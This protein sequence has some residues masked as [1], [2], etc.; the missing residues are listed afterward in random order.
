MLFNQSIQCLQTDAGLDVL[1]QNGEALNDQMAGGAHP[2]YFF[3]VL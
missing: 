3:R 1:F 2:G